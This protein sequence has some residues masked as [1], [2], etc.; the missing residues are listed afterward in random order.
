MNTSTSI[1]DDSAASPEEL[2]LAWTQGDPAAVEA[3]L[4]QWAQNGGEQK[5]AYWIERVYADAMFEKATLSKS[6][7]V[8]ERFARA[9]GDE[10]ALARIAASV[11]DALYSDWRPSRDAQR[12][13]EV[14]RSVAF[15]RLIALPPAVRLE[16]AAGLLAADLFGEALA[17]A[18]QV[19]DVLQV[20]VETSQ[21]VPATVR[22]NALG[23]GLEYFSGQRNWPIAHQIEA[24]IEALS[25]ETGFGIVAQA[26][27][28]ARRG[29]HYY[30]R[31]GDYAGALFQS[32]AAIEYARHSGVSRAMRESTITI[33][34]C[35]LMRGEIAEAGIALA[36]EEA[37]IPSGHLMMRAN[38]C[39]ER[40]WLH[41]LCRD[42]VSAQQ[43][44]DA[45]CRLFA[46]IDEHGVMSLA[47]P[48]LQAQLL[49][50]VGEFDAALRVFEM[51]TRRPNAWIVDMALIEALAALNRGDTPAAVAAI[52]RGFA[53]AARIDIKGCMWAC[54]DELASLLQLALDENIEADWVRSVS[55][56][57]LLPLRDAKN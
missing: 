9:E 46:E 20:W 41:A 48:S 30:Y 15:A 32:I 39:Y 38:V 31:R 12:W 23:Y 19:A 43:A 52:R 28:A 10:I 18:G 49:A 5:R 35:R 4:N 27:A 56:A 33:T 24:Q 6:V 16:I 21:W 34:L 13:V 42:V 53:L 47:T 55:A 3:A 17:C 44:L 57:R 1:Q 45:A 37:T 8:A 26:R 25:A 36:N 7:Q 54:R 29:F 51:R 40:S 11:I 22:G 50:Q 2:N 14:L